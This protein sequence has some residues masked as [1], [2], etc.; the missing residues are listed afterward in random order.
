MATPDTATAPT[1]STSIRHWIGTI[2]CRFVVPAWLLAGAA[3]KLSDLNPNLL[4]PPVRDIVN[5]M[6][7]AVGA[8]PAKWLVLNMQLIVAVELALVAVMVLVPKFARITAIA[9]LSLFCVILIAELAEKV[10]SA[11][12]AREG[13]ASLLKPCGCFG[14][15]SPP[16]IVTFM[17]DLALLVGCITC[18]QGPRA[19][20]IPGPTIANAAALAALVVAPVVV[21]MQPERVVIAPPQPQGETGG[22]EGTAQQ[23]P[24]PTGDATG[25][26]AGDATANAGQSGAGSSAAVAWPAMP[27]KLAPTYVIL[28][29]RAVGT[30]F[31][32][33][34]LAGLLAKQVPADIQSG[35][36]TFLFY[37]ENCDHCF[38]M[39]NKHFAGAVANPTYT[40]KVPDSTGGKTYPNPCSACTKWELPQG[41]DYMIETPMI[42]TIVNG[43][44]AAICKDADKPGAFDATMQA[45][46]PGADGTPAKS[47]G[48]PGMVLAPPPTAA[49]AGTPTAPPAVAPATK[50]FP[51]MPAT[52]E[53]YYAPQF[54]KWPGKRLDELDLP[55]IIQRPIPVDLQNGEVVLFFYRIDCDHCAMVLTDHFSGALTAPTLL[56]SIPDATGEAFDNPCTTCSKAALAAGPIYVIETPVLVVAKDGVVQHVLSGGQNDN[57]DDVKAVLPK[58][59]K[60]SP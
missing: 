28:D 42:M 58:A 57:P 30:P 7:G 20:T 35:R 37:R 51:P 8:D 50:P 29:K 11:T 9:I 22:T 34:P 12:F 26:A 44:I 43:T 47:E 32:S 1:S 25:D 15:W 5:A 3:F 38:E 18:A 31:A 6:G 54:D 41:P 2:L 53:A 36:K 13:V 60:T 24:P 59:A 10:Q 17:I 39:M 23:T 21:F 45:W 52:L 56:V 14:A 27:E 4:P 19:R 40:I 49:A 46:L 16:T 33:L 48:V 55:L